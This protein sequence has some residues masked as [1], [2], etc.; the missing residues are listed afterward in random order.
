LINTD[1]TDPINTTGMTEFC[2]T[3]DIFDGWRAETDNTAVY[4]ESGGMVLCRHRPY[5]DSPAIISQ[6]IVPSNAYDY[7]GKKVLLSCRTV[8]ETSMTF[9]IPM[10]LFGSENKESFM[11]FPVC[12]MGNLGEIRLGIKCDG[13]ADIR[14]K[15]ISKGLKTDTPA[16][17]WVKM[18]IVEDKGTQTPE[19]KEV[20]RARLYQYYM[21][22]DESF[23][24]DIEAMKKK[25]GIT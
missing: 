15:F 25:Y 10:M 7:M 1:F 17:E 21:H 14:V 19:P 4:L 22:T 13:N 20:T 11:D 8:G 3:G 18:E 5:P 23:F 12:H 6:R 24:D 2:R 16:I 9:D